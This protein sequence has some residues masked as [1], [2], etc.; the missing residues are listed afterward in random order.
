MDASELEAAILADLDAAAPYSVYADWLEQQ[1]DPRGELIQVQLARETSSDPELETRER[2]LLAAHANAWLGGLLDYPLGPVDPVE[3]TWRR[4]F[5]HGATVKTSYQSDDAAFLYRNLASRPVARFLRD[6]CLGAACSHHGDPP[7]DVSILEALRDCPLP[8]LRSLS[9][10]CLGRELSWTHVGDVSI[11][12]ASL[13]ELESLEIVTGRMTLGEIDLP[14]LRTLRLETGGLP[15]HVLESIAAASWPA[16]E[17]L[18]I[19]FGTD[20]YG[21]T[22]TEQHV[23]P[24]LEGAN[25]PRLTTLALCNG[26]FADELVPLVARSAILPR[27]RRLDLSKG[28]MG[29]D[30]AK[31]LLRHARAFTHLEALDLSENYLPA[32]ACKRLAR[33]GVNVSSQKIEGDYGR[34]VTVS[35]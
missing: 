30:G 1:G 21:G 6:L 28:T 10:D 3:V 34:Y 26:T 8:A 35:E 22:C 5:V 25:L 24:I 31:T 9:I 17:T 18:V 27:L 2:E 20:N 4:G 29:A 32:D 11:A 19:F 15:A 12:N 13:R 33:P 14:N 16:L 23:R 7:D